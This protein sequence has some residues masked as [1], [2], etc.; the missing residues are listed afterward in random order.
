M[1]GCIR[2]YD[3]VVALAT[4]ANLNQN[5]E[6]LFLSW[7]VEEKMRSQKGDVARIASRT[8]DQAAMNL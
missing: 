1:N 5:K 7:A 4:N 2:F 6:Y 3:N 8:M